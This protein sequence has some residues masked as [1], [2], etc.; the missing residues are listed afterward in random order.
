MAWILFEHVFQTVHVLEAIQSLL[1]FEMRSHYVA[2]AGLELLDSSNPAS[3][4][5]VAGT[6][7]VCHHVQQNLL[8][9]IQ[10]FLREAVLRVELRA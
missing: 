2:R 7:A 5:P 6:T 1:F 3:A 8:S 4:S 10:F 9:F